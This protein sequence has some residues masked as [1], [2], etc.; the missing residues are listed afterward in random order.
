[1]GGAGTDGIQM[2]SF[3][4]SF[5][6]ATIVGTAVEKKTMTTVMVR[7]RLA[8]SHGLCDHHHQHCPFIIAVAIGNVAP[9]SISQSPSLSR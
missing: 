9:Q 5:S 8:A 7:M 3:C 2:L 4:T 6:L 1:M